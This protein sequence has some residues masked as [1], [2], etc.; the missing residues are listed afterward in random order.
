MLLLS[1]GAVASDICRTRGFCGYLS[2]RDRDPVC[3]VARYLLRESQAACLAPLGCARSSATRASS[4]GVLIPC[5]W[6]VRGG[7]AETTS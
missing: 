4:H 2:V 5:V 1:R 7:G 3:R 6:G